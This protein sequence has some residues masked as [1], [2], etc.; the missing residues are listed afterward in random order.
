M[1]GRARAPILAPL[2]VQPHSVTELITLPVAPAGAG[3][4]D[5]G[6]PVSLWLAPL[7]VHVT[8]RLGRTGEWEAV[9]WTGEQGAAT[10]PRPV[11]QGVGWM[12]PCSD[13]SNGRDEGSVLRPGVRGERRL[14]LGRRA[15]DRLPAP[16]G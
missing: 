16:G 3:S 6:P 2:L 5:A 12:E 7:I 8:R 15:A 1:R 9:P 10:A 13:P 4:F 11:Q 14:Y